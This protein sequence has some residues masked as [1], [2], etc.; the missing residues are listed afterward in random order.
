MDATFTAVVRLFE[1]GYTQTQIGR[2]LNLSL[3]KVRKI[4]LTVGLIETEESKFLKQGLTV[5]EI[6]QKL[7]KTVKAVSS[8]IPYEKGMYNAEYPSEN[9]LK[10][11]ETRNK[12]GED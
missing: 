11:R 4:L 10:I 9:A 2:K 7:N 5:E 1:Q 3:G 12:K 6:A 8:R